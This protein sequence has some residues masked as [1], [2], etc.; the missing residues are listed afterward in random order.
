MFDV[1]IDGKTEKTEQFWQAVAQASELSLPVVF[2][3]REL[4][5]SLMESHSFLI[6]PADTTMATSQ[7]T[8]SRGASHYKFLSNYHFL[9]QILRFLFLFSDNIVADVTSKQQKT[10]LI[11]STIV[12]RT[13]RRTELTNLMGKLCCARKHSVQFFV[14]F[15]HS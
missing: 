4:R 1:T 8:F 13:R 7:G 11:L 9:L 15:L 12:T 2:S 14:Q 5:S 3:Q 6:L 10:A